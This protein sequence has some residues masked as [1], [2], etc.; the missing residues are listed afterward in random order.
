MLI[1]LQGYRNVDIHLSLTIF[2][3]KAMTKQQFKDL[4][5]VTFEIRQPG[6]GTVVIITTVM[7]RSDNSKVG[8][9]TTTIEIHEANTWIED[10]HQP[11]S[12]NQITA[13]SLI[14]STK[15]AHLDDLMKRLG[16]D[17]YYPLDT[18]NNI[19]EFYN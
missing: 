16:V 5:N 11:N 8:S 17:Q 13:E 9:V 12:I 15:R 2:N 7:R 19:D 4:F 18:N 6:N 10:S 3:L 1:S 14:E